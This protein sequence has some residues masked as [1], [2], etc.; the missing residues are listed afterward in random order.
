MS[1]WG[2]EET[3]TKEV[4]KNFYGKVLNV[5]AGDGRFNNSL[6]EIADSVVAIDYDV[7]E[8]KQLK[9]QTNK[10]LLDKLTIQKV[11]IL[12]R[13]PFED[14]EFDGIFCTGTLHLFNKDQLKN[15]LGEM[16]RV[17]KYNGLI[18]LDF[19]TDI[20]R[21]DENNNRVYID[22]E[23]GYTTDEAEEL[24][25]TYLNNYDFDIEVA[26]FKE[27]DL[28][29]AGYCFIEGNFLLIKGKKY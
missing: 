17:L 12:E 18:I 5:A 21:L 14:E 25:K 26:T 15:I 27:D 4:I 28:D 3:E 6:L 24:F 19:A 29:E 16:N 13:F 10:S 2:V 22:G 23:G 20:V 9:E 8:L 1:K 11:N 7:E